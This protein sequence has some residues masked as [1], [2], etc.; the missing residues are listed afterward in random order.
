M[1]FRSATA[2]LDMATSKSFSPDYQSVNGYKQSIESM[3]KTGK[4]SAPKELY[5]SVRP[6]FLKDSESVSYVEVRFIDINPLSKIGITP[7]MLQFIHWLV[8]YGC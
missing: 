4:I 7:E 8:I 5:A 1:H 3:V 2:A 6:K